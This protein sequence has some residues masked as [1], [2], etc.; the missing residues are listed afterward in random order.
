[1]SCPPPHPTPHPP[2]PHPPSSPPLRLSA[3]Q[4][5]V[6]EP[7][8]YRVVLDSDA[9]EFGG[10]GR[11]GHDVDHFS[12]VGGR[13]GER[14]CWA[15]TRSWAPAPAPHIPANTS[16]PSPLISRPACPP[17]PPPPLAARR[18]RGGPHRHILQP[19]AVHVRAVSLAHRGGV[20]EGGCGVT[21]RQEHREDALLP[22]RPPKCNCWLLKGLGGGGG[23]G[24]GC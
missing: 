4:V 10:H 7:G 1:M 2:T 23:R 21:R 11:V 24:G 9:W 22:Q 5:P 14:G 18:H 20:Q 19:R 8:K 15:T 3:T 13:A 16:L 12:Q 17:A 6:P